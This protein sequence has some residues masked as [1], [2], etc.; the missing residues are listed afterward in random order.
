MNLLITG[1]AG[2]IGSHVVRLLLNR[3]DNVVIVDDFSTGLKSRVPDVPVIEIDLADPASVAVLSEAFKEHQV[4]AVIHFAAKKR[5][6]ESVEK[7]L[8]YFQQNMNSLAHVLQ[9]MQI[10][11]V[12]QIVFSSSAAVYGDVDGVVSEDA[13]LSPINPYGQ[14]KLMG[15]WLV[16]DTANSSSIRGISLRYFNVAGCGW[17]DLAD[18]AVLNLVPM[19]FEKLDEDSQP[20]IFGSDYPTADGTCERDFIHVMDLADAHL[21]AVDGISG[22]NISHIALNVGTG[23]ATSVKKMIDLIIEESGLNVTAKNVERR[24]GDPAAVVA[25]ASRI[26]Q[27]LGWNSRYEVEDIVSSAWEAHIRPGM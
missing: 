9:A 4:E 12:H 24:P 25:D 15:E 6:D 22:L 11:D 8:F 2:Y 23:K 18:T 5:V 10:A 20:L 7:P 21:A 14:T 17:A 19:V 26:K 27:V 1:G 13:L 16:E 3:G